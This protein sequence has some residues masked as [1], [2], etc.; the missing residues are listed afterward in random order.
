VQSLEAGVKAQ[1][2]DVSFT[3]NGFYTGLKNVVGQG[4]EV[5]S[6]T[7]V[8]RWVIQR[9]PRPA[10]TGRRSKWRRFP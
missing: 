8:G 6:L 2:A 9:T 1:V 4:I 10:P 5:D 7:G 3:L